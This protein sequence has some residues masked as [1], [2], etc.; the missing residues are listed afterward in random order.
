[1][2]KLVSI[3]KTEDISY[4]N[5]FK[6]FYAPDYIYIPVFNDCLINIKENDKVAI[7]DILLEGSNK[8]YT[9]PISGKVIGLE[10]KTLLGKKYNCLKLE[11]DYKES[12]TKTV[13]K[14][15]DLIKCL[16]SFH[17]D[18]LIAN[19]NKKANTIILNCVTDEPDVA[20]NTFML[21]KN[22]EDI[23][24]MLDELASYLKISNIIVAIKAS[25]EQGIN[26][27]V[28]LLGSYPNIHAH[29]LNDLYLL[30][31]SQF[32]CE[33][34]NCDEKDTIVLKPS[35][36]YKIV[37]AYKHNKKINTK[38]ITICG[39]NI[40]KSYVLET[41]IYTSL[42][43]IL[44]EEKISKNSLIIV[45]GLMKGLEVD[46]D[47]EIISEDTESIFIMKPIRKKEHNCINCGKCY[48]ICPVKVDPV[49]YINANK[50]SSVC[51][52]CGL[53]SYI[54]PCY[55]N[56]RKHLKGDFNE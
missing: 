13:K 49:K 14:Q 31:N 15:S 51:I 34:L 9:S 30:E 56:L 53:C 44:S 5:K 7:N 4:P 27:F 12:K 55:I 36:V 6:E 24:D 16:E 41:K 23:I 18:S 54:C 19:I 43:E 52:D 39:N 46:L 32:L 25:D 29:L 3:E 47:S 33:Y 35:D 17:Y 22:G 48:N 38:Y 40:K 28:N 50:K 1:M 8:F 20:N 45:N 21:Q 10:E 2:R 37:N 11:N 26:S 42:K